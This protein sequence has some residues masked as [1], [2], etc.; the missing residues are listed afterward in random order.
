MKIASAKDAP[1]SR[2]AFRCAATM[3]SMRQARTRG[4][5][6]MQAMAT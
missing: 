5:M 3:A 1:A 2:G 4:W 6:F